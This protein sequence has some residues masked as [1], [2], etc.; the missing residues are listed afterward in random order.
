MTKLGNI[1]SFRHTGFYSPITE[2]AIFLVGI[3][4]DQYVVFG[5]GV[6]IGPHIAITAC[7]VIQDFV[8][9]LEN[10]SVVKYGSA[11]NCTFNLFAVHF[12]NGGAVTEASRSKP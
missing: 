10:P 3:N 6:I 9:H 8:K 12:T 4:D 1:P 11:V 7:H 2:F 5:S